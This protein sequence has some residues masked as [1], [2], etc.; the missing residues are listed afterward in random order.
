[1]NEVGG[2]N[3]RH[4]CEVLVTLITHGLPGNSKKCCDWQVNSLK[5]ESWANKLKGEVELFGLAY[6]YQS[7]TDINANKACKVIKDRCNE[8][9]RMYFRR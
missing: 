5:V 1:M 8:T 2:E 9:E 3:T 4:D 7:Q 6:I